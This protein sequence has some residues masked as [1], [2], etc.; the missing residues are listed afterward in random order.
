MTT[1]IVHSRHHA[2][3]GTWTHVVADPGSRV[4]AIID[5]VLD[6]DAKGARTGTASAEAVLASCRDAG[7]DVRWILETLAH[8]D[9]LSAAQWL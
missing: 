6:F 5:P 4:A 3:T 7:F 8:A 2:D 1:P 9:H